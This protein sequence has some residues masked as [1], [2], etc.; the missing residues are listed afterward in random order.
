MTAVNSQ[1]NEAIATR[2]RND[3]SVTLQT[4]ADELGISRQRV[5]QIAVSELGKNWITQYPRQR[6]EYWCMAGHMFERSPAMTAWG[7]RVTYCPSHKGWGL[8]CGMMAGGYPVSRYAGRLRTIRVHALYIKH[9]ANTPDGFPNFDSVG[10][11]SRKDAR[12]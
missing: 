6:D 12:L 1:R 11:A 8:R 7:Y 2:L 10:I 9:N 5:S 4:I 3:R